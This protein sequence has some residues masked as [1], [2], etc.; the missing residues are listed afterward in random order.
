MKTLRRRPGQQRLGLLAQN[1]VDGGVARPIVQKLSFGSAFGPPPARTWTPNRRIQSPRCPTLEVS[2]NLARIRILSDAD[3]HVK[4]IVHDRD[5]FDEP[6]AMAGRLL[7]LRKGFSGCGNVEA[8]WR[9]L[10]ESL[11]G[12]VQSGHVGVASGSGNMMRDS[13]IFVIIV[14]TV[15]PDPPDE[16]TIVAGKPATV[17]GVGQKPVAVHGM[18]VGLTADARL[19]DAFRRQISPCF[20]RYSMICTAACCGDV[21]VQSIVTS[22]FAGAS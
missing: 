4:M 9:A 21:L 19:A 15:L 6:R 22:G 11:G 17:T 14:T 7:K 16:S 10:H 13:R 12:S 3:D 1:I 2:Q 18:H 20:D 8:R 5:R